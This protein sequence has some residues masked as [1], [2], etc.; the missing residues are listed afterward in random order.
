MIITGRGQG[1]VDRI[2]VVRPAIARLLAQWTGR[3]VVAGVQEHTAG[4]FVVTLAPFAAS[5]RRASLPTPQD[6]TPPRLVPRPL[7]ALPP[8][9]V[10]ALRALAL[11]EL[12]LLGAPVHD[13]FLASEMERR[14]ARLSAGL[15]AGV[16]P[17]EALR[18]AIREALDSE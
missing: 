14:F 16:D 4:S 3:G 5:V 17:L 2:P 6:A 1:S 9:V 7:A 11:H 15:P 13:A 8:D 12:T 18:A 10:D